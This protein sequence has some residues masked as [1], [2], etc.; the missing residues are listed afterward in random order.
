VAGIP[1]PT[2][3]VTMT[4]YNT[5]NQSVTSPPTNLVNGSATF[6][7]PANSLPLGIDDIQ[8]NYTGDAYYA[9]NSASVPVTVNSSGTIKPT[10]TVTGPTGTVLY[11]FSITIN[12]SGPSGSPVPTGSVSGTIGNGGYSIEYTE[13]LINGS[14]TFTPQNQIP[15]GPVTVTASYLGDANYTS[16]SGSTIVDQFEYPSIQLTVSP[17]PIVAS[18]PLNVTVTVSGWGNYPPPTGSVTVSASLLSGNSY[19]SSPS[20]LNAGSAIITI[21]GNTLPA[22][23]DTSISISYSGDTYYT[24]A[25]IPT[26]EYY[27]TVYSSPTGITLSGTA[28]TISTPGATTANTSTVTV[29]SSGGF[30]GEVALTAVLA[31]KPAGAV[32]LPTLSFGNTTPVDIPLGS[33]NGTATLTITTTAATEEALT[34]PVHTG[35]GSKGSGA[36]WITAGGAVMACLLLFC[37]PARRRRWRAML[38]MVALFAVLASSVLS[39]G[40]GGGSVGGGGGGGGG[41]GSTPGTTA[42]NYTITVTGTSGVITA[43][44]TVNLTVQ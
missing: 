33:A 8:G 32:Y 4:Y 19:T 23:Y 40:G 26:G 42:G 14:V 44:S 28:V 35:S 2:G 25:T 21:P 36:H 24:P 37:I 18:L 10:V 16:G 12:V 22:G 31:T 39:C 27:Y 41:G 43:T 15:G 30:T 29:T 11:P 20:Q 13:P 17:I 9:A 38:G 6:S 5:L 1:A 34:Y 7:I 3:T